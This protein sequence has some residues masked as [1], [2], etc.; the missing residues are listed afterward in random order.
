MILDA[1]HGITINITAPYT[2]AQNGKIEKAGQTFNNQVKATCINV[3]LPAYMWPFAVASSIYVNNLLPSSANLDFKSP[4]KMLMGWFDTHEKS[5]KPFIRH[6]RA[7]DCTAYVHLK[8]KRVGLEKPDKSQKMHLQAIKK[9]LVGYEG[10]KG[11]LFKI[12]L[13]EKKVMVHTRDVCFFNKDK[14]DDEDIQHLVTF[15]EIK[16]TAEEET[17]KKC[18]LISH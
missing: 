15:E 4:H 8:G 2:P 12:W 11:H 16:K 1:E 18:C 14:E 7:F 3:G 6:L 9:Y 13:S 5:V 17:K 10:L